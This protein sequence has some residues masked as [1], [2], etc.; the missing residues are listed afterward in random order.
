MTVNQTLVTLFFMIGVV[1]VAVLGAAE[2]RSLIRY[3]TARWAQF[4]ESL[5]MFEKTRRVFA[6][7]QRE[8]LATAIA[9]QIIRDTEHEDPEH[10]SDMITRL[11]QKGDAISMKV[12]NRLVE[13][14]FENPSFTERYLAEG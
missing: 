12:V 14:L 4:D 13:Y 10:L 5:A 11:T 6:R 1:G 3:R 2:V 8:F 7:E 9:Y